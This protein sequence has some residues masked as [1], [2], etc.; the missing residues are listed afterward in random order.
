MMVIN[1][2]YLQVKELESLNS[3]LEEKMARCGKREEERKKAYS[4]MKDFLQEKE[5]V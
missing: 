2:Y 5:Q 1:F 3:N 4:I